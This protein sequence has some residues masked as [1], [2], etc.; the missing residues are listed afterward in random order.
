MALIKILSSQAKY[1]NFDKN[2]RTK[3]M[4]C[5]ASYRYREFQLTHDSGK[6]QKK[7]DK[8][9]MLCIEF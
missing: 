3:A 6:K 5:C 8:Y 1:I 7:L 4:K 9:P 2:L